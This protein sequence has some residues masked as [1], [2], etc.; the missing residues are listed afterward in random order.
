[1]KHS[2]FETMSENH[3]N[4][5]SSSFRGESGPETIG[6]QTILARDCISVEEKCLK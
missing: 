4:M 3:P 5:Y 1:M 2:N 6:H